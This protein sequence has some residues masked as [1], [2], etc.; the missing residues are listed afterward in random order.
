M[1]SFVEQPIVARG[2][3]VVH[4]HLNA[5]LGE[6]P[7]LIEVAERIGEGRGPAIAT[8]CGLRRVSVSQ[9]GLPGASRSRSALVE[10][11]RLRRFV[12]AIRPTGRTSRVRSPAQRAES[13]P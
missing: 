11:E 13:A 6:T 1:G 8:A 9:I 2:E 4:H 3:R 12:P 10:G 7:E 5:G